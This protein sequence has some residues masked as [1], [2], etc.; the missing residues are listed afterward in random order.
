MIHIS[1]DAQI[2]GAGSN[3]LVAANNDKAVKLFYDLNGCKKLQKEAVIQERAR[4]LLQGIVKVPQ[5]YESINQRIW[6]KG[7]EYLCGLMMER[8]PLVESFDTAV[9]ILLGYKQDDIDTIWTRDYRTPPTENNP[10]RGFFAGPEMM[11]AIWSDA[12]RNDI[13]V[14]SVARTMGTALRRLIDG[15]IVPFDLEFIYGG[16]GQIYLIDFGF[17]EFGIVDPI[18]YLNYTGSWGLGGDYYIPHVGHRGYE[19]FM[20]G[21][22]SKRLES[23]IY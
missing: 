15:G 5:I 9:H 8:V 3:G 2:L 19:E 22:A 14:E 17:C 6:Y 4:Q 7:N 21:F 1:N 12:G 10:P 11:E 18:R 13:S 23:P 16:D 20:D